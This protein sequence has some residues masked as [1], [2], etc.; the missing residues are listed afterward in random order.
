MK[1][2][3]TYDGKNFTFQ[4]GEILSRI[5]CR[6][7]SSEF[8][9]GLEKLVKTNLGGADIWRTYYIDV[10]DIADA[11][12]GLACMPI[13]Y[14]LAD[15]A[16][17]TLDD[18]ERAAAEND[19]ENGLV[20]SLGE[21]LGLP[22]E[23]MSMVAVTNKQMIQGASMILNKKVQKKLV[24]LFGNDF[25]ILPSSVHEVIVTAKGVLDVRSLVDMVKEIN[26]T[27]VSFNERLSDHVY[28]YHAGTISVAA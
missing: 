11:P 23:D 6:L 13:T 20:Q 28:E 16:G 8:Y 21:M 2:S 26:Q 19:A 25:I 9:A 1:L 5:H 15:V 27:A 24:G 14:A 4:R 17:L 18:L 10:T 12:D 3:F 7:L 22:W